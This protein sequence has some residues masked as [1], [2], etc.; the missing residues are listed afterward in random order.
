VKH[1][2]AGGPGAPSAAMRLAISV[3]RR[4]PAGRYPVMER[5]TRNARSVFVARLAEE[6]GGAAFFCDLRD[7]VAREVCF[8]GNYEPQETAIVHSILQPGMTFVDVGANWGYY[9]LLAAKAVG[10]TGRVAALEPDPRLYEVLTRNLAINGLGQVTAYRNAAAEQNAQLVLSGY[11][12]SG[13]NFGVSRIADGAG[14]GPNVFNVEAMT[15]DEFTQR[16]D[17]GRIDLLK[18][19]I[20]GAE[21][22]ALVGARGLL[23]SGKLHRILIELHPRALI[24]SGSSTEAVHEELR[25]AGYTGYRIDHSPATTRRWAYGR[26]GAIDSVLSELRESDTLDHWPHQLWC[27][28]GVEPLTDVYPV[29]NLT[30]S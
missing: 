17:I 6:L 28:S 3:V 16:N 9:T 25:G 13:G 14:E 30:G 8:M 2:M 29:T 23:G 26:G 24:E 18:M 20:E 22:R 4:L 21:L 19:D 7:A 10:S 15:L 1:V 27:R 11:D 5:I 12:S